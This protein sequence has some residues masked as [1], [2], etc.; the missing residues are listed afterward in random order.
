MKLRRMYSNKTANRFG[1]LVL[2]LNIV[3][4]IRNSLKIDLISIHLFIK[5]LLT[6]LNSVVS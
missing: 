3:L 5:Y 1:N 6:I 4:I 2:E